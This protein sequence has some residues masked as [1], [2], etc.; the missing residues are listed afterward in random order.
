[1]IQPAISGS[2]R[3]LMI[4]PITDPAATTTY[5]W[6]VIL[7]I[8]S[9]QCTLFGGVADLRKTTDT[10]PETTVSNCVQ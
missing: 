6:A 8:K 3:S 7:G 4:K 5:T 2:P 10:I 9:D 1:M